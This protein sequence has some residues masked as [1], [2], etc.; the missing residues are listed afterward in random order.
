MPTMEIERNN[1]RS[2]RILFAIPLPIFWLYANLHA[3]IVSVASINNLPLPNP[4]RL[5]QTIR[6]DVISQRAI[7]LRAHHRKNIGQFVKFH[8]FLNYKQQG[9]CLGFSTLAAG[10]GT[11]KTM[12]LLREPTMSAIPQRGHYNILDLW[13]P[14]KF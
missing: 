2:Q 5:A 12:A 14:E 11:F 8:S 10:I 1:K 4:D 13:T 9:H 3:G 7:L 6:L